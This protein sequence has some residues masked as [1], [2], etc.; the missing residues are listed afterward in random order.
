M[1]KITNK[2][3]CKK[4]IDA[5]IQHINSFPHYISRRYSQGTKYLPQYLKLNLAQN[6]RMYIKEDRGEKPVS[7]NIERF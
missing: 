6:Y 3:K 5:A 1:E 2:Q 4:D 7:E